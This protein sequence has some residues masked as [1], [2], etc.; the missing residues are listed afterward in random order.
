MYSVSL[1]YFFF[2]VNSSCLCCHGLRTEILAPN[3]GSA[4]SIPVSYELRNQSWDKLQNISSSIKWEINLILGE[5]IIMKKEIFTL[6]EF[7]FRRGKGRFLAASVFMS[8]NGSRSL[9]V[10]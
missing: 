9:D 4:H 6:K 1:C 5:E 10:N 7:K 2:F 8:Q 3:S